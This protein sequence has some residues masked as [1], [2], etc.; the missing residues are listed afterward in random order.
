MIQPTSRFH[1]IFT[2]LAFLSLSSAV[3][4]FVFGL[5]FISKGGFQTNLPTYANGTTSATVRQGGVS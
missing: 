4:M 3:V 5:L 2:G 1:R